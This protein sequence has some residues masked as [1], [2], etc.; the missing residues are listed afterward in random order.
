VPSTPARWHRIEADLYRDGDEY[1]HDALSREVRLSDGRRLIVGR[2][3]ETLSD[4]KEMI[5]EAGSW[6]TVIATLLGLVGG[7][8]LSQIIGRRLARVKSD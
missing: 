6:A 1:D 3:I 4:R 8:A 2:D 7:L 5:V